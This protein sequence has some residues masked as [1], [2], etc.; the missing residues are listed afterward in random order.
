MADPLEQALETI[1][2]PAPTAPGG[3]AIGSTR[4]E[5]GGARHYTGATLG[6]LGPW[7]CP[8]CGAENGGTLQAGCNSCGSGSAQP[9]HVG[10]P[11]VV[12]G[13]GPARIGEGTWDETPRVEP[14]H[15]VFTAEGF[16]D[17]FHARTRGSSETF[18]RLRPI[19]EEAWHAAIVWYVSQR[20]T[21]I[22]TEPP[23]VPT[24]ALPRTLVE[25]IIEMLAATTDLP[26]E[27]QSD[28]LLAIIAEL[29]ERL[30]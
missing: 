9:R 13:K 10:V 28:E 1:T 2:H 4:G 14:V 8:S 27:Q 24:V 18:T 20:P 11:Q 23:S 22:A 30:E 6:A 25:K 7:K 21:V 15:A 29:R 19:L 12:R 5:I 17:W 3:D 26:D 16:D